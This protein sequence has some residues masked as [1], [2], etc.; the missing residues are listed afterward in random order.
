[1]HLLRSIVFKMS[2]DI[3]GVGSSADIVSL[4]IE[5]SYDLA[6]LTRKITNSDAF[7]TRR[8]NFNSLVK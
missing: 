7:L 8:N 5:K 2:S 4:T 3:Q 1:M 6:K